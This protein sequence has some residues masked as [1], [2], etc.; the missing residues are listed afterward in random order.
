MTTR[1]SLDA[2]KM[3]VQEAAADLYAALG[4]A[5]M[6][7]LWDDRDAPPGVKF[8]DA[9]L[10]GIPVR[11]TVGKKTAEAGTVDVRVRTS[12]DQKTVPLA[13]AVEAVKHAFASYQLA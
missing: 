9:D 11:V 6:E 12:K 13:E 5:G 1:L 3:Q 4:K 10:I 7:V 8:A 2:K